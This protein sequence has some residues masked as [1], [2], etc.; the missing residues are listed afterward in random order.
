MVDDPRTV[1]AEPTKEFFIY[2]ITRDIELPRAI[3][4]LVDNCVDGATALRSDGSFAGL[5]VTLQL[6]GDRFV[7]DDNCGGISSETARSYAFRFGRVTGAAALRHSIGQFGVG[8]KRALFKLG[9]KFAVESTTA[10][11]RFLVRVD[12][13]EWLKVRS[14]DFAFEEL[15]ETPGM[16]A[17]VLHGT[18]IE[19][20]PLHDEIGAMFGQDTFLRRL[21]MSIAEAH[22]TA[23]S[24][25][26]SV[27]LRI[28]AIMNA[29]SGHREHLR[30]AA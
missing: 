16:F 24:R 13:G 4:D 8:M 23:L 26:L 18:R 12:V 29:H 11:S 25:G 9:T 1:H 27:I 19:V 20:T 15:D 6:E 10:N 14:W 7:V 5:C 22:R 21:G 17:D 28:P 2:M 3:L 30:P